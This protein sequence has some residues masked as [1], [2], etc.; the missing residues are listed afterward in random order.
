MKFHSTNYID[1]FIEVAEDT[2]VSKGTV[3]TSYK[4]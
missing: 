1:T 4:K 2:Q 3:R